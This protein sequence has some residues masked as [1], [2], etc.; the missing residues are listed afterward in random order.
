MT[1]IFYV[2]GNDHKFKDAKRYAKEFGI[3]LIQKKLNIKEIQ[4]NSIEKIAKDKAKQVFNILKHPLIVN[5]S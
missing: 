2:T 3:N 1:K 5:D 4:S